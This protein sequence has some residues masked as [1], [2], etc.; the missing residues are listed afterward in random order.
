MSRTIFIDISRQR[1]RGELSFPLN[2]PFEL[3]FSN[4]QDDT[5][6]NG[7]KIKVFLSARGVEFASADAEFVKTNNYNVQLSVNAEKLKGLQISGA[8]FC[9]MSVKVIGGKEYQLTIPFY[10]VYVA[11]N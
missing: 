4:S 7:E 6:Y 11:G 9:K 5:T 1:Q 3:K 2:A 8:K 10:S